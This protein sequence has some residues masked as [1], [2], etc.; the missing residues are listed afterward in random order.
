MS[1]NI[2]IR[3]FIVGIM[4]V[5]KLEGPTYLC[6]TDEVGEICISSGGTASQYWGLPGLSNT[7]FKVTPLLADGK[8]LSDTDFTRSGLLGFLGPV[9]MSQN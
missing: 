2:I 1:E 5:V 3:F 7:C 4:V 9:S 6:K 8:P